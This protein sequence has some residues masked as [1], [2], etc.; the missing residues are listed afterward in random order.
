MKK[1]TI[2]NSY[3]LDPDGNTVCQFFG[4]SQFKNSKENQEKIL[5]LLN[6]DFETSNK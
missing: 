1:Y 4:A 2:K 5:S 3:I 6:K